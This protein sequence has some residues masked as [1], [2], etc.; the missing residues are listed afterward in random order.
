VSQH[1]RRIRILLSTIL[2]ISGMCLLVSIAGAQGAPLAQSGTLSDIDQVIWDAIRQEV[3]SRPE[4]FLFEAYDWEVSKVTFSAD[5]SS[6]VVWLDPLDPITGMTIATEPM[7]VIVVLSP[8]GRVEESSDWQV[9]FQEDEQWKTAAPVVMD[10]LP[11]E[12]AIAWNEAL[13]APDTPETPLAAL[14]GYKLPWAAGLTKNLE[15]STEHSSCPDDDCYYAFDFADGTMFPLLAAKGG[16]VEYAFD[17]CANGATDCTNKIILKDSSTNPVSY[18]IYL[19]LA[20]NSIPAAFDRWRDEIVVVSQGEYIGNADDTGY[21]S[22][23]H[24]HFMVHQ[25]AYPLWGASVDITFRDVF[26]NWDAAT[27]GGR[28]RTQ[29]GAVIWPGEWQTSYT[30]GNVG[31]NPPTGGLSLPDDKHTVATQTLATAGWGSDNL[32]VTRMQLIAYFEDAWHEVGAPQTANPFTY[33]LDVCSA[34]IPAG[35]FN[36]ALRVWDYEGNQTTTPLGIRHLVNTVDCPEQADPMCLPDDYQAAIYSGNNYTGSCKLLGIGN[37]SPSQLM[38]VSSNDAASVILGENVQLRMYDGDEWSDR[39][40]TLA[41]SDR[42]LADNQINLDHLSSASVQVRSVNPSMIV[43]STHDDLKTPHGPSSAYP[44]EFDSILLSWQ[45]HGATK[46]QV[47]VIP[48]YLNLP[49]KCE[50]ATP[51]LERNPIWYFM[52]SWAIGSLSI[53]EYTVCVRGRI[54]EAGG[55]THSSTWVMKNFLVTDTTITTYTTRTLPYTIN[56]EGG[57]GDWTGSGLWRRIPDSWNASND[58]WACNNA[59]NDY[60]DPTYGGGDLT[61]PPIQIPAGGATLRFNYRYETESDQVYWDQ[62]WVQISQN[63]G[64]FQNLIQLNDDAMNTWLTSPAI[65]LADYSNSTVRIRFHFSTADKYYNGGLEGWLVDDISVTAPVIQGCE[66]SSNNTPAT[67]EVITY[68]EELSGTICPAGDVDYYKFKATAGDKL[69]ALVKAL[70]LD[71]SSLLDT[72]LT[73]MDQDA[74]GNSP[75]DIN[76]DMQAG[77]MTDSQLYFIVPESTFTEDYYYLKVKSSDHPSSG[78]IDYA[79]SLSLTEKPEIEDTLA[80]NLVLEYPAMHDGVR[81]EAATFSAL[82]E[83]SGSG[84]S[85]VDFWW[86]SPN[87]NETTWTLLASDAYG[88]D[89]W[90][91]GFDGSGYTEGQSGALAVIAYDWEDNARV[92]AD[93]SVPIDDH[94]PATALNP[95]SGNIHGNGIYLSWVATDSYS[96]IRNLDI[97]YQLDRSGSWQTWQTGIPGGQRDAWYIVETGHRYDFRMRGLDTAGNQESYPANAETFTTSSGNC[98]PDKFELGEGDDESLHA[99]GLDLDV[100]Q[101]DH[102]YC[103]ADDIDWVSFTAQAGRIYLITIWPDE[104][105]P[106]GSSIDLYQTD[107]SSPLNHWEAPDLMSPLMIK[108]QAPADGLYLLKLTSLLPGIM[109]DN[110]AYSVRVGTGN[111]FYYPIIAVQ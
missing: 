106:L 60:G 13:K 21:S 99:T 81:S 68:G 53:G 37:H 1:L 82:A 33:N 17:D 75:I 103:E 56:F 87:W 39:R 57:A 64:R 44:T 111:W 10:L 74:Y 48:S 45:A 7:T 102:N 23:H 6:A 12:L 80:P 14:G 88:E 26:I 58:L 93:W 4:A 15:W 51:I 27:Q 98:T 69:I 100:Y 38:P 92:V 20:Q 104:T 49:D 77:S 89:G 79:Y 76:D 84:V 3:A 109:G 5:Q 36:L 91:A 71:P 35:P 61:S 50:S 66:E 101:E 52:P 46:Y 16:T 95:L 2:I 40:E 28:P 70:Q 67:A 25:S 9:V 85:R 8:G 107:E 86:H 54:S 31:A 90:Q 108:W 47:K 83:D 19:H 73:L 62:R 34:G 65:D 42:N 97:Q 63:G 59:D 30:S 96:R 55:A 18:Q 43:D 29:A 32:G 72:H 94:P 110:T 41:N 22:G 105:S 24:L 11:E 78:G